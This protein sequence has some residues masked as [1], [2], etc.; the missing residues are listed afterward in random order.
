[1]SLDRKVR[2]SFRLA[3]ELGKD[4]EGFE[5]GNDEFSKTYNLLKRCRTQRKDIL[6]QGEELTAPD[7]LV[8]AAEAAVHNDHY[9]E[10]QE[11]SRDGRRSAGAAG[12]CPRKRHSRTSL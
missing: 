6:A 1:M 9:E 3:S 7:I 5:L 2:V 8:T 4:P 11:A 12:A 10:A